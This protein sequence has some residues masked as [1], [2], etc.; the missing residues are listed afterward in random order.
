MVG[1][2]IMQMQHQPPVSSSTESHKRTRESWE[3]TD[4]TAAGSGRSEYDLMGGDTLLQR[5]RR[6]IQS[7]LHCHQHRGTGGGIVS[8]DLMRRYIEY[9]RRYVQPS[10]TPGAAKVLQRLYLTMRAEASAGQ[11]IPV[12]TRHLESLIRLSQ[13]R[14]RIDLRDEVSSLHI[15]RRYTFHLYFIL[16]LLLIL[17]LYFFVCY[18]NNNNCYYY[19]YYYYYYYCGAGDSSRRP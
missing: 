5:L 11:S 14:A 12:T 18:N 4:T 10:L 9:A 16:D 3:G 1:E 2:H 15:Q 8:V 17:V 13:A 7:A 6:K 19:Y